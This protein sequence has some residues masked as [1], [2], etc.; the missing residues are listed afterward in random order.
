[1]MPQPSPRP[2]E[3]PL[4]VAFI[5]IAGPRNPYQR[6]Q[7]EGMRRAGADTRHGA[8]GRLFAATRTQLRF[9]PHFIH[10]DWNY[11]YF[12]RRPA[13]ISRIAA[14]LYRLDVAIA[15]R[16]G[17]RIVWTLHNIRTHEPIHLGL[18]Q[19][20]QRW[21]ARQCEWIRVFDEATIPRAVVY[22]DADP[23]R[24]RIVP[25]GSF[26]GEYPDRVSRED[27]RRRL[28]VPDD[29]FAMVNLGEMRPYKGLP[30]LI[31]L[32]RRSPDPTLRA[33]IAGRPSVPSVPATLRTLASGDPRII[34]RPE[35]VPDAEVGTYMRAA[36]VIVLPFESIDNSGSAILAMSFGLP[37]VAPRLGAL[38]RLL[39]DQDELLYEPGELQ[40][41]VEAAR[42]AGP[43]RLRAM[44]RRNLERMA[45]HRW[46]AF[47]ALFERERPRIPP[48]QDIPAS[49][50]TRISPRRMAMRTAVRVMGLIGITTAAAKRRGRTGHVVSYHNVLPTE[51]LTPEFP[52]VVD[53]GIETFERQLDLLER[54][55]RILP[56]DAASDPRGGIVLTFDDGMLNNHDVVAP[57]LAARGHTAVFAIVAGAATGALPHLWRDRLFLMLRG[58]LGMPTLLA[59]DGFAAPVI[60]SR[61]NLSSL[62]AR[63]HHWVQRQRVADVEPIMEEIFARNGVAMTASTFRPL[64]FQPM[65]AA[66]V[67]ALRDAGHVIASH[68]WS[69]PVL[70]AIDDEARRR[71][72]ARSREAL[73]ALLGEKVRW[74]VYPYG[75]PA[76]VDASVARTARDAG[77]ERAWMNVDTGSA[78]PLLLPRFSM[79]P[80]T[81][82]AE[83]GATLSGLRSK[84]R[85]RGRTMPA[86]S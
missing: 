25:L 16:L 39:S 77:Y 29:A 68:T 37:V 20:V 52:H 47:A 45:G 43:Q 18:Q 71:E 84:W 81:S 13:W 5:P 56:A 7:M 51:W 85:H 21:F 48:A 86:A 63:M 78:D 42:A 75:T 83:V 58:R 62:V 69:H 6:L 46:E 44:G 64:R 72:L 73:E 80:S 26:I 2:G 24:F 82:W 11:P 33:I 59:D 31:E 9:R 41:A 17:A 57:I 74:L 8:R 30:A 34:L 19:R 28:D 36:D 76:A 12:L 54:H 15:R 27:A 38:P 67:R 32:V 61:R 10:Y 3:E 23:A 65:N 4:R 79:P 66:Q 1:M 70:T 49:P 14:I 60:P 35:F 53:F 50:P 55:Y 22:L 40:R